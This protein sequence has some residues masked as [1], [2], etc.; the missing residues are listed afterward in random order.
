MMSRF[1]DTCEAIAATS[2][3][4][5]KVQLAAGFLRDLDA[6]EIGLGAC[7]LSGSAFS[8]IDPRRPTVGGSL[9]IR[10]A[11]ALTGWSA[12]VV[13]TCARASG[14]LGEALGLLAPGPVASESFS[15]VEARR[16]YD[17]L[18]RAREQARKVELLVAALRRQTPR[19]VKYFVKV[20]GGGLRIGLLEKQ[21]EEAIALATDSPKTTVHEAL[22]RSGDI[23]GVARAAR[24]G[25]LHEVRVALFHPFEFMLASPIAIVADVEDPSQYL[26]EHKYDGIR[27]Q[28]HVGGG[29]VVLF[30]RGLG[31]VTASFPEVTAALKGLPGPLAL[32]GELL[33]VDGER[34][35]PFLLLQRRLSRKAPSEELQREVGVAF[36]AWD[37]LHDRDGLAFE[38]P[39]EERRE[40]LAAM[41]GPL[42]SDRVRLSPVF[43][44]PD[45][46][47]LEALFTRA[48][49]AGDE[50]LILKKRASPYEPGR[51]GSAWLKLKRALGTLDVV[52]TGAEQGHGKRASLLSDYT[53]A[54]RDGDRFVNVGRAFTGL[55]DEE[56]RTLTRKLQALT[57]ERFGRVRLIRP[58]L[59]LEV[60][61]DAV[62]RSS[63]HQSGYSLRFPRIVRLRPDKHPH[64]IDTLER[65]T[66]IYEA[67]INTGRVNTTRTRE[68]PPPPERPWGTI[69]DL[70]LFKKP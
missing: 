49:E 37:L 24:A 14:D 19:S 45:R 50:G 55:T 67:A 52:I 51:R 30:S 43:E 33:A 57:L 4:L 32:D 60:A 22:L 56:S 62:Q 64:E 65:V 1:A 31:E 17:D 2:S 35:L 9:L 6:E 44:A 69:D 48:R 58:E 8:R 29:R 38:R 28:A 34:A 42:A 21:V 68:E 70:P 63:R 15:L 47:A 23:E 26:V 3:R 18:A 54:V 20:L 36:V 11:T 27:A 41:V 40:R 7:F 53:F 12:D 66:Q 46:P 5:E 39:L 59:V 10:A 16:V 25:T 13:R 61:F